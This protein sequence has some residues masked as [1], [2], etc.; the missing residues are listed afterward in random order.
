MFA[1]MVLCGSQGICQKRGSEMAVYVYPRGV[2]GLQL[3]WMMEYVDG[4]VPNFIDDGDKEI[5]F[6]VIKER[7][8]CEDVVYIALSKLNPDYSSHYM[9]FVERL[10]CHKIRYVVDGVLYYAKQSIEKIQLECKRKGWDKVFCLVLP[11]FVKDKHFGLLADEIIKI[12]GKVLYF[13][14]EPGAFKRVHNKIGDENGCILYC[15]YEFLYLLD[16]PNAICVTGQYDYHSKAKIVYIGHGVVDFNCIDVEQLKADRICCVGKKFLPKSSGKIFLK[17]GYLAYD[18]VVG[19]LRQVAALRD[20]VLVAPYN[21]EELQGM[22]PLIHCI[23]SQYRVIL[24]YR[25][26]WGDA[27]DGVEF[28][29]RVHIDR[30]NPT[31][32]ESYARAFCLICGKTTTKYSFPLLTLCP[33][34]V[35]YAENIDEDLGIKAD[36]GVGGAVSY[37]HLTLPTTGS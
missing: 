18:V 14:A 25:Y 32:I 13:C 33:C 6:D 4:I 1:Q 30:G 31:E 24:R 12:G 22:L 9:A 29:G 34:I 27:L 2:T 26:E 36:I 28:V 15:S 7:I 5:C 10:E 17:S 3:A 37:T 21:L 19:A 8:S 23:S 11:D 16:F 20:S 35:L